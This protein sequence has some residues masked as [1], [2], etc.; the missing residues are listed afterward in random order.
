MGY[1]GGVP[2]SCIADETA[3]AGA[4]AALHPNMQQL[5][6]RSTGISPLASL[7]AD[8]QLY[9]EPVG[10]PC[11][12]TW[13]SSV[14]KAAHD[15]GVSVM[16]TGEVG[17]LTIS[18][19]GFGMLPD[20]IRTGRWLRWSS[21]ARASMSRDM[22]LR[23][24]LAI[25][26]GPW[27][28]RRLWNLLSRLN[29]GYAGGQGAAF[30]QEEWRSLI[31][32][33]A[34]ARARGG[35]PEKDNR[36]LRWKLLQEQDMGNFR[37]GVLSRWQ[38]DERD[39]TADRRLA[40]FCF[41]LPPEQLLG[42]GQTRRLA[43]LALADRLPAAVLNGPRGYQFADWH[44]SLSKERLWAALEDLEAS[45]AA[46]LLD[47]RRLHAF[48][49]QWPTAGWETKSVIAT[50]RLALLRTLSAGYFAKYACQ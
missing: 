44:E 40:E 28:P 13:L 38:I 4:T 49:D 48:V 22:R 27:L 42:E 26:F 15:H 36:K 11:N 43:R 9:Q 24:V 29:S 2:A 3:L 23:G 6:L 31:A 8:S 33:V 32:P 14:S 12:Q 35:R 46:S 20:F 34:W 50:H 47:L 18:A 21:E 25:S 37:K 19:G 30:L 39:P 5:V 7:A 10:L 45:P 17:N 41:A 16:L 1:A